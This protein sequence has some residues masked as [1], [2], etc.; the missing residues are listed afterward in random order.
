M[1]RLAPAQAVPTGPNASALRNH[2]ARPL[3]KGRSKTWM[4]AGTSMVSLP[5]PAGQAS[6]AASTLA[7]WIAS[8]SEQ[9]P[10]VLS[11]SSVVLTVIVAAWLRAQ[12]PSLGWACGVVP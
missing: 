11:S 12:T 6:T 2:T 8:R 1:G 5:I 9:S 10:S 4:P 3:S 7:A